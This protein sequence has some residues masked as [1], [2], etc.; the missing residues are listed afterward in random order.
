MLHLMDPKVVKTII[1]PDNTFS[2]SCV[3][4]MDILILILNPWLLPGNI[5]SLTF[6]Y[7]LVLS[8]NPMLL[9]ELLFGFD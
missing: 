1:H 5:V 7:G 6:D 3:H 2:F 9:P 4:L 8:V